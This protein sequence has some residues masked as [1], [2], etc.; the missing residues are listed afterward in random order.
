MRSIILT[1]FLALAGAAAEPPPPTGWPIVASPVPLD[2]A[3]PGRDRVGALR[4]LGGWVLSS[5][6]PRFGGIS[7]LTLDRGRFLAIGDTGGVF[8]FR[9]A[10]GRVTESSIAAL[11]S[12]PG[13]T[14]GKADRDAESMAFDP[15]TGSVWVGFERHNAVW[16]Y[17]AAVAHAQRHDE[18]PAMRGW[19]VNGG[20]EAMARLPDG[21]FII[22]A[23]E[24]A[25]PDG[26]TE[27]LLFASDPAVAGGR[28]VRFGYRPP[29]R[30]VATDMAVL[31]DGRAVVVN[32]RYTPVDGVSAVLTL[33]DVRAIRPGAVLEGRA[34][35]RLAPPLTVDNMEA[36]A[37][38][39]EAGRT[40][41]WIASD[42]NF[43]RL[44]RTLL[45]KFALDEAA[46]R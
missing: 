22:L 46:L 5:R 18:P 38:A 33:V 30:Y 23:E 41:L 45:L 1:L 4:W 8:R 9:I 11:P 12:G 39:E 3:Q 2:P 43:S 44:Q 21:R 35:A 25:G 36:L 20:P 42:D 37:I 29:D 7:A 14:D 34:L 32:R 13:S 28:P 15:G 6:D 10:D 26:S 31:R 16:C 17:D 19:P 27:G 40:I 24:A